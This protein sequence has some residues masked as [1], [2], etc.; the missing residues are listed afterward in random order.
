MRPKKEEVIGSKFLDRST[1]IGLFS[2]SRKKKQEPH[3]PKKG[4]D[5]T[6]KNPELDAK[7]PGGRPQNVRIHTLGVR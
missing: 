5:G 2:L 1:M 7:K 6:Q 3:P 4:A